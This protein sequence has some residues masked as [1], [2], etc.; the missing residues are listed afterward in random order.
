MDTLKAYRTTYKSKGHPQAPELYWIHFA[1]TLESASAYAERR[2]E[3]EFNGRGVVVS[4]EET[5]DP[6]Q[7]GLAKEATPQCPFPGHCA[8]CG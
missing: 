7:A 8:I 5:T 2:I 4:T 1:P 3:A 6:R